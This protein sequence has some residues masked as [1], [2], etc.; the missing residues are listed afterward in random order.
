MIASL[1]MYDRPETCAANDRFWNL[2]RQHLGY[3][4]ETLTRDQDLWEQW[5]SPDLV[6]SQT[7]GYPYRAVLHGKATLVATPDYGLE[8]CPPGHYRSVFVARKA[9][10]RKTPQEFAASVFAYNEPLS[11]SGWAAPAAYAEARGFRFE[12]L[13]KTGGHSASAKSVADG[14]AD[15]AALDALSWNLMQAY[16]AFAQELHVIEVTEPTPVLPYITA[17]GR[18]AGPIFAALS[19]AVDALSNEDRTL[20]SLKGIQFIGASDYLAVPTP[21]APKS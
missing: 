12:N 3:G 9:D 2:I 7:C 5:Q 15:L 1:P 19:S 21:A 13:V 18:D 17:L 8:G 16:D 20:L 6:L 4:P 14:K 10:T 11:Q